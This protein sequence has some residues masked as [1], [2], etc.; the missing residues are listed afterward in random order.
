MIV[1]EHGAKLNAKPCIGDLYICSENLSYLIIGISYVKTSDI[2]HEQGE[3]GFLAPWQYALRVLCVDSRV[4]EYIF[5]YYDLFV[6]AAV[7]YTMF[8]L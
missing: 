1:D 6:K 8:R 5:I 4:Y 3:L 2:R 7:S